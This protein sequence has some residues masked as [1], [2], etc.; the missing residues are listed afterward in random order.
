MKGSHVFNIFEMAAGRTY[1]EI[2]VRLYM[3]R[4]AVYKISLL[5]KRIGHEFNKEKVAVLEKE[6]SALRERAKKSAVIV[7]MR[8]VPNRRLEEL[9]DETDAKFGID[10]IKLDDTTRRLKS[11][12]FMNSIIAAEIVKIED[13]DGNVDETKWDADKVAE[14]L[15][16]LSPEDSGLLAKTA[17]ELSYKS[18]FYEN[19]EVSADF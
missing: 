1:P 5:E 4:D 15:L 16:L 17:N 6:Q 14:L 13:N 9:R 3:D 2:P 12:H 7:T 11:E 19:V 18:D 8:G 10:D